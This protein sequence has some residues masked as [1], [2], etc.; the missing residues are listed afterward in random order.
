[1]Y[2]RV[3]RDFSDGE[4]VSAVGYDIVVRRRSMGKLVLPTGKLVACDPL[5]HPG[6]EPFD[7][8]VDPGAYPVRLYIAELRDDKRVAYASIECAPTSPSRWSHA[9]CFDEHHGYSVISSLG[10]FMDAQTATRNIEY[11]EIT[12]YDEDEIDREMHAQFQRNRKRNLGYV[13][14]NIAHE[15]L[16]EGNLIVFSSGH[17]E[18][19]YTTYV[20]R[21]SS[22]RICRVVTDFE[23]LDLLFPTFMPPTP[24]YD[25]AL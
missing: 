5:E 9:T 2:H 24:A 19:L 20:G 21:D 16:G 10:A 14:G 7:L 22:G 4:L 13:S 25:S 8:E 23:V 6:T 17:G 15:A 1:M 11:T 18:G 3:F 12:L